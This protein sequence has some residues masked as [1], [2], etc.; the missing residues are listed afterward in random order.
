MNKLLEN[1]VFLENKNYYDNKVYIKKSMCQNCNKKGHEFHACPEPIISVGIILIRVP[2]LFQEEK[3][4]EYQNS[5]LNVNNII[6]TMKDNKLNYS[7]P[8]KL[9][10]RPYKEKNMKKIFTDNKFVNKYKKKVENNLS[11]NNIIVNNQNDIMLF[12][13]LQDSIEFLVIMRKHTVGFIEFMRGRYKT[14][15]LDGI[16]YL[17]QQMTPEEIKNIGTLTFDE[18]W[19]NLWNDNN[20]PNPSKIYE[21]EYE[22]S[23]YKFDQ[24]KNNKTELGL[25]FYVNNI[26]PAWTQPEWGFPKGRRNNNEDNLDCAKREFQE[27]TGL[28]SDDY[29]VINDIDPLIEDFYGT[30]GKYYRHIYYVAIP[31]NDKC[32]NIDKLNKLQ[33]NEIGAIG[34]YKYE[35]VIKLIRPYHIERKKIIMTL[36]NYIINTYINCSKN[37]ENKLI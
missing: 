37:L 1:K 30:N 20:N 15:N 35:D 6:N 33:N 23:K 8:E 28:S 19:G 11:E 5:I 29:T 32:P 34:Y 2:Q 27:E 24:L 22:K 9:L 21:I 7:K 17:F 12:S 31:N 14:D 18:L 4:E 26:V 10:V 16:I 25:D 36:Y 3:K 13:Y